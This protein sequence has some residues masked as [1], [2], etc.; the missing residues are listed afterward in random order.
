[1]FYCQIDDRHKLRLFHISEAEEL[2]ELINANSTYLRQWMPWVDSTNNVAH[3]EDYIRSTL[4]QFANNEGFA[5][6]ICDKDRIIG[7]VGL[8]RIDQDNRIGYIGYWLAESYQGKGIMTSSCRMM[9]N[10]AFETLKLNRLVI[11]CATKNQRSRAIP[12]RLGF[13]HEGIIRDAEW[14]YDRFVDHDVY[15]LLVSDK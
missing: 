8:N 6:A 1:M 9:I 11:T 10:Y 4:Q 5:A 2:C 13:T 3:S 7:I 14:L 15:A 12:L